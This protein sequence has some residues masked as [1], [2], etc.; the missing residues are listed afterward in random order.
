[1]D[2]LDGGVRLAARVVKSSS[3][4]RPFDSTWICT[5]LSRSAAK[6]DSQHSKETATMAKDAIL[7][8]K[9]CAKFACERYRYGGVVGAHEGRDLRVHV[10]GELEQEQRHACVVRFF[11]FGLSGRSP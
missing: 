4:A 10:G 2:R 7:E 6:D 1:M 8:S 9:A 5:T 11:D 3:S